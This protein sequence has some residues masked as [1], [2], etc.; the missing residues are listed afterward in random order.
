M[1]NSFAEKISLEVNG[2]GFD[3]LALGPQSGALI[4]FLHGFPEFA[5]SWTEV[6]APL[7][8][9]GFRTVAINQRGYSAGA[10]PALIEQYAGELLVADTV[11]FATALSAERFHLV[12]HD[13][14]GAIAWRVAAMHPE[15]LLSLTVLATPHPDAFAHALRNDADQRRRSEY[16]A[17]FRA[18]D[19]AAEKLLLAEEA[20]LLRSVYQGML[21]QA[22]IEE[23]VQRFSEDGTLTAAL[24]WYRAMKVGFATGPIQVPTMY[25]WGDQDMALGEAAALATRDYVASSFRFERMTGKSHWLMAECPEQIAALVQDQ[26]SGAAADKPNSV[27]S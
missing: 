5:D 12:G 27:S 9:Q 17:L 21:P 25:I 13:W 16:F 7:A 2:L 23:Y 10:R 20:R 11:G 15:R 19:H 1:G 4:L 8:K 18:S 26:C 6:M 24:N 22:N 14:G 3:G